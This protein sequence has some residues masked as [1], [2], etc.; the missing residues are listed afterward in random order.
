[1]FLHLGKIGREY[2][3]SLQSYSQV[4]VILPETSRYS[5]LTYVNEKYFLGFPAR[6]S[7]V[8][9]TQPSVPGD[10]GLSVC[11]T[12]EAKAE[13]VLVSN[14]LCM[15][16]TLHSTVS[17]RIFINILFHIALS[18]SYL[19]YMCLSY[20]CQVLQF[21]CFSIPGGSTIFRLGVICL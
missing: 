4:E 3:S 2:F 20:T 17:D 7:N 18:R 14:G 13:D 11:L 15:G 12:T 19:V 10:A 5:I 6:K 1:M 8:Y 9:S 16:G 21:D